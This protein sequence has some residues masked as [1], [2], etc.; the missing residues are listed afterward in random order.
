MLE[1]THHAMIQY[2]LPTTAEIIPLLQ[3]APS[4]TDV[5]R[6]LLI[7]PELADV[8]ATIIRRVRDPKTGLIPLVTRYD[9]EERQWNAPAPVASNTTAVVSP[10]PSAPKPS[11]RSSRPSPSCG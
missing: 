4:K 1:T 7:S 6:V 10:A 3:I 8:L 2:R 9:C 5:E 11:A